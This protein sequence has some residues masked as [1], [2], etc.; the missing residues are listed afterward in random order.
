M[1]NITTPIPWN[2]VRFCPLYE[3]FTMFF[4]GWS[5]EKDIKVSVTFSGG[6]FLPS[7]SFRDD[8]ILK[9]LLGFL[10]TPNS[11]Y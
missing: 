10:Q 9:P 2:G 5:L 3:T 4:K 8:M 6:R 7:S 11:T 1:I